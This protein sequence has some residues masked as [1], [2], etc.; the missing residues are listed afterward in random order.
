MP[1]NYIN[2]YGEEM[3]PNQMMGGHFFSP[4][5]AMKSSEKSKHKEKSKKDKKK[6]KKDKKR[7]YSED[8]DHAVNKYSNYE[9][10]NRSAQDMHLNM[11]FRAPDGMG[12][13]MQ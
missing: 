6:K 10:R 4:E 12:M 5:N 8:S 7:Q 2:D 9:E 13:M 3:T 11:Q 1:M